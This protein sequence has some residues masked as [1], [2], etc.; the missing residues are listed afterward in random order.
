[1]NMKL[2][3]A[4]LC[5]LCGGIGVFAG[6]N[7]TGRRTLPTALA[8]LLFFLLMCS[9]VS[10]QEVIHARTGTVVAVNAADKTMTL[11]AV[12]GSKLV[13]KETGGSGS[14]SSLNKSVREKTIPAEGYAKVGTNVVVLYFGYDNMTA[15]AIKELGAGALKKSTGSV[16]NFDKHDRSLTLKTDTAAEQKLVLTDDTIVDTADGVVKAS[17]YHPSKGEQVRCMTGPR[18]ETALLVAPQ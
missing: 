10:A 5:L 1:M 3:L 8:A 11:K 13:F 12:D 2:T 7:R 9:P 4:T 14:L 18:S 16:T 15:V 17:D 6:I